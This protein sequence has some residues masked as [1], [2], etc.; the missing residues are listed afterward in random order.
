SGKEPDHDDPPRVPRGLR[1]AP[2]LT[3]WPPTPS[4]GGEREARGPAP[5]RLLDARVPGVDV[6]SDRGLRRHPRLC[7]RRAAGPPG[8]DGL[9]P[10]S[11]AL[12]RGRPGRPDEAAASRARAAALLPRR[13]GPAARA[14]PHEARRPARRGAAVPRPG[15]RAGG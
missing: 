14:G 13:L 4:G 11:R 12:A 3:P 7:R 8:N 5:A 1:R 15:G 2:V 9:E 6:A 10:G